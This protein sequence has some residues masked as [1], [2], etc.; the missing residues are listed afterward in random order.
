MGMAGS[1]GLKRMQAPVLEKLELGQSPGGAMEAGKHDVLRLVAYRAE[2]L[3]PAQRVKGDTES[4][5]FL[6]QPC[7]LVSTSCSLFVL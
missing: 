2:N 1:K 5:F 6:E 7:T 4:P 3:W